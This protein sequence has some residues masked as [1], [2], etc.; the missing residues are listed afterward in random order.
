MRPVPGL[1]PG[2]AAAVPIRP[3]VTPSAVAGL[4][5]AVPGVGGA[6][7]SWPVAGRPRDAML[8][9]GGEAGS[10]RC[11]LPMACYR[12]CPANVGVVAS[13]APSHVLARGAAGWP[14]PTAVLSFSSCWCCCFFIELARFVS[15]AAALRVSVRRRGRLLVANGC[16]G[17]GI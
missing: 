5:P 3:P 14:A 15:R 2:V 10:V 4:F 16:N 8:D 11:A 12:W 7:A 13:A 9:A 1:E 6:E 17:A